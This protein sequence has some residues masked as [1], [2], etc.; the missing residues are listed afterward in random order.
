MITIEQVLAS[1]LYT[2]GLGLALGLWVAAQVWFLRYAYG[3]R[4]GVA[5]CSKALEPLRVELSQ[6][7]ALRHLATEMKATA[8]LEETRH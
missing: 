5:M 6:I 2:F 4:D 3:F 7:S 8:T 1:P